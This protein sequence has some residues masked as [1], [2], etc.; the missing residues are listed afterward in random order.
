[1]TTWRSPAQLALLTLAGAGVLGGGLVGVTVAGNLYPGAASE[2]ASAPIAQD[3]AAQAV[4]AS[5]AVGA[6]SATRWPTLPLG[7]AAT[8][9][10]SAHARHRPRPRVVPVAQPRPQAL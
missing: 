4:R 10:R 2:Q 8:P 7:T 3:R 5:M 9:R 1:M 6:T